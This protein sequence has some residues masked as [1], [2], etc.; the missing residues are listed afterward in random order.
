MRFDDAPLPLSA[1]PS[2]DEH[3]FEVC[4]C[5]LVVV[6]ISISTPSSHRPRRISKMRQ[7]L[8]LIREAVVIATPNKALVER[9]GLIPSAR[10]HIFIKIRMPEVKP[11]QIGGEELGRAGG[12]GAPTLPP[13]FAIIYC[14]HN[15]PQRLLCCATN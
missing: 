9:L 5:C 6:T 2:A 4:I 3:F 10:F 7:E 14:F 12:T 11:E 1:R 13:L 8:P 15:N